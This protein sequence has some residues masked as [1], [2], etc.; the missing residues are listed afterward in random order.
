MK[1]I[2][3]RK[4]GIVCTTFATGERMQ[5]VKALKKLNL[6]EEAIL[7]IEAKINVAFNHIKEEIK[8]G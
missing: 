6:S 3:T 1:V 7:L 2:T 5:A 4:K 8:N